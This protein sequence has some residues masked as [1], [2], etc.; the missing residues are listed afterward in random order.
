[1]EFLPPLRQDID[2]VPFRQDGRSLLLVRDSL[3][4]VREGLALGAEV[5]HFL[6]FF[7]GMTSPRE[8]QLAVAGQSG[9]EMVS[10]DEVTA[11]A[12][13]LDELGLLQTE[14]YRRERKASAFG[15]YIGT[16]EEGAVEPLP[17]EEERS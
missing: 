16:A 7:D 6:P 9:G 2:I 15:L 17:E 11:L 10:L 3:G 5:A 12:E 4:L 13:K 14:R 8:F 1:M